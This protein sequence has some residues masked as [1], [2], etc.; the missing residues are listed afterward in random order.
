MKKKGII[1]LVAGIIIGNLVIAISI[2]IVIYVCAGLYSV[3]AQPYQVTEETIRIQGQDLKN[4]NAYQRNASV[5]I[6]LVENQLYYYVRSWPGS[7][8]KRSE[9]DGML[10]SIE[11]GEIVPSQKLGAPM[12]IDGQFYYYESDDRLFSYDV[13]SG[14]KKE[15][16]QLGSKYFSGNYYLDDNGIFRIIADEDVGLCYLIEDG[17]ITGT[18]EGKTWGEYRL[19]TQVYSLKSKS[20]TDHELYCQGRD[21]TDQLA[22]GNERVLLPYQDGLLLIN[23]GYGNLLYFIDADGKIT[24]IFPEFPCMCSTSSINFYDNYIFL[25]FK[26]WK[27]YDKSGL[28]LNSYENDTLE[29]TYRIDM[30]DGTIQKIS[31][32]IYNG[33]FIFDDSG[34]FCTNRYGDIC[35]IDFDGN[36]LISIVD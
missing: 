32:E 22:R 15:I 6:F 1:M 28:G 8:G 20:S 34:I 33:M 31:D 19:G 25:S 2:S 35:K 26:R 27:S 3:S 16:L 18:E 24:S 21:I 9:F 29:G 7:L 14:E 23:G 5:R 17:I 30:T 36:L 12:G 4:A 13:V 11:E 10:C